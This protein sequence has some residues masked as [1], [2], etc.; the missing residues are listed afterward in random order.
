MIYLLLL[1]LLLFLHIT[2]G[3]ESGEL[4]CIDT[5]EG[6]SIEYKLLNSPIQSLKTLFTD[7]TGIDG[8]TLWV[9]YEGGIV[10]VLSVNKV[11]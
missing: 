1:L 5:E 2:I 3:F 6:T 9:L 11:R 7:V 4:L 10:A 8:P